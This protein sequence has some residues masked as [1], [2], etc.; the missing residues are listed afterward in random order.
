M[1]ETFLPELHTAEARKAVAETLLALFQR[2]G[3]HEAKQAELL[4]VDD[5]SPLR[6]GDPLPE[7]PETLE[8]AGLILAIDRALQRL[9]PDDSLLRDGWVVFPNS[10]FGGLSPLTVMLGGLDGLHRVRRVLVKG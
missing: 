10:A 2:W 6:R 8:R 3:L 9:Y 4:A 7:R 5:I 1:T